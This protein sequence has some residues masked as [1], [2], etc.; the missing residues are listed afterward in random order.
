[1]KRVHRSGGGTALGKGWV[2][3][4]DPAGPTPEGTSLAALLCFAPERVVCPHVAPGEPWL[5]FLGSRLLE[6][7]LAGCK[8]VIFRSE[9]M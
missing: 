4:P 7:F 2:P 1:M 8:G 9:I 5:Q 3:V 6:F